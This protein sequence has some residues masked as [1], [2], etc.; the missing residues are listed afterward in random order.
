[1][2]LDDQNES[3]NVEDR[4]GMGSGGGQPP[5]VFSHN[6]YIDWNN[7]DVTFRDNI[8]MR[9]ANNGVMIRSG[10]FLQDNVV[11]DANSAI[12]ISGGEFEGTG[13]VGNFTLASGNV[14][15]APDTCPV[16]GAW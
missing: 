12:V 7:T 16:L 5:G 3:G 6:V 8:S 4:R 10:G 2:R 1:M 9:A 14:R 11:M 13:M 15:N